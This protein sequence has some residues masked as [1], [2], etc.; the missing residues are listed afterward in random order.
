MPHIIVRPWGH[1]SVQDA[2]SQLPQTSDRV[3]DKDKPTGALTNYVMGDKPLYEL[4]FCFPIL[5]PLGA[6]K[7]M[8][9]AK[10]FHD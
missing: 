1:C 2:Y 5:C 3:E 4:V 10:W 6:S 8:E 9:K 7:Y